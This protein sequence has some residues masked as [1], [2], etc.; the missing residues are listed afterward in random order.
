[1]GRKIIYSVIGIGIL[2]ASV[3]LAYQKGTSDGRDN[4]WRDGCTAGFDKCIVTGREDGYKNGYAIGQL[5]GYLSGLDAGWDKGLR[6]IVKNGCDDE[7]YSVTQYSLTYPA[8]SCERTEEIKY[9][10]MLRFIKEDRTDENKY[11]D[12]FNCLGFALTLKA[13]AAKQGIICAVV[14]L[15]YE[16]QITGETNFGHAINAFLVTDPPSEY[17]RKDEPIKLPPAFAIKA[18]FNLSPF[19]KIP[20][21]LPPASSSLGQSQTTLS[22]LFEKQW[23]SRPSYPVIY[24]EPQFDQI[25]YGLSEGGSYKWYF[26]Y[27]LTQK[28]EN[29][30]EADAEGRPFRWFVPWTPGYTIV[31]KNEAIQEYRAGPGA[32]SEDH[33]VRIVEIW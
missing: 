8:K 24:V 25:V 5:I 19:F 3:A 16:N 13:N 15:Y 7:Y 1:M 4:G 18:G 23:V 26:D 12:D 28:E 9:S 30:A 10:E 2:I 32:K 27:G 6:D 29:D 31:G 33:I 14:L 21:Q 17:V 22:K 11:T 20:I